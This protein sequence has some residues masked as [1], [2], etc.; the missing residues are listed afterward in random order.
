[1]TKYHYLVLL[2]GS[3]LF[4]WDIS[5]GIGWLLGWVF[6]GLLR[7][8]R[9]RILENVLDMKNLNVARYIGYLIG[10]IV[11]LAIPLGITL[12]F[13]DYIH[14]IAVFAAYFG[15]RILMFVLNLFKKGE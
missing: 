8:Y 11:W 2:L 9:E 1:M 4:F 12:I 5:Y 7:H 15:D 6:I 3:I 10:I 13:P 14:P